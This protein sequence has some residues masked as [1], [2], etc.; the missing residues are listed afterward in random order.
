MSDRERGEDDGGRYFYERVGDAYVPSGIGSSPWREDAQNGIA[1][2]GLVA[3]L[4][5][6]V[7][8]AQPMHPARLQTEILG[9]VP[10]APLTFV[11]RTV[12]DGR[13]M[14]LVECELRCLGRAAVRASL[15]R[16]RLA[17]TPP[18]GRMARDF[19]DV[20]EAAAVAD[21]R[22]GAGYRLT[23]AL[24]EPG[25]GSRWLRLEVAVVR[26]VPISPLQRA[27]MAAD[28]GSGTASLVPFADW[29]S[30]NLDVSL[31]LARL[32]VGEWLHLDATSES[33]GNGVGFVNMRLGDRE[34]GIGTSHQTI[35]VDRR[36]GR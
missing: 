6:Q 34:G 15:L 36:T 18:V 33:A 22:F 1:L 19:P 11:T 21:A 20:D 14:Q 8:C 4:V 27:A 13:R 17:K 35:F 10:M 16:A 9:A 24:R 29:T 7:P 5:E 28:Y 25:P 32:P 30:A 2:A 26:G 23:G 3:H 12:R 31:H